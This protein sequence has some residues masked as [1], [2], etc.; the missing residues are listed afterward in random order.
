[1]GEGPRWQSGTEIWQW[2]K[3]LQTEFIVQNSKTLTFHSH[4]ALHRATDLFIHCSCT[5]WFFFF[6]GNTSLYRNANLYEGVG[7]Q[8]SRLGYCLL[9]AVAHYTSRFNIQKKKLLLIDFYKSQAFIQS[10]CFNIMSF[11][12]VM[13]LGALTAV[14]NTNP[15]TLPHYTH[16]PRC[17]LLSVE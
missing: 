10:F 5:N 1:M 4:R 2:N 13:Y 16:R 6:T 15:T 12:V 14:H 3:Q 8:I 11:T 9:F 7:I 17:D